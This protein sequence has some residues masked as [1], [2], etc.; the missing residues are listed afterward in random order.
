M[1]NQIIPVGTQETITNG[2]V[3]KNILVIWAETDLV[4]TNLIYVNQASPANAG[5][6]AGFTLGAGRYLCHV[7]NITFTGTATVCYTGN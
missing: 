5:A 4:I 3:T 1:N 2:T 6:I 7:T